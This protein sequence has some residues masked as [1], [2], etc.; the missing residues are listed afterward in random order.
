MPTS[1]AHDFLVMPCSSEPKSTM[2]LLLSPVIAERLFSWMWL[3]RTVS[4]VAL[5][6]PTH[7]SPRAEGLEPGGSREA[8]AEL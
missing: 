1:A 4:V 8:Q 2:S 3:P 5:L 7:F 6:G